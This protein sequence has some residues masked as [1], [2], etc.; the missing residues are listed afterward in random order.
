MEREEGWK[1][2]REE[3]KERSWGGKGE[4]R[5][6]GGKKR[7]RDLPDHVKLLPTCL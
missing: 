2:K 1:G 6:K 3:G 5:G 4:E 7:G